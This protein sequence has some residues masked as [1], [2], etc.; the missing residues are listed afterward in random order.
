[1]KVRDV[2]LEDY[3]DRQLSTSLKNWAAWQ[4]P[5]SGDRQRLLS[6]AI[7]TV[8]Q[9]RSLSLQERIKRVFAY[10]EE[11]LWNTRGMVTAPFS[12]ASYWAFHRATT[13]RQV[14]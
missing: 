2:D 13:F 1:M 12:Q 5:P 4:K 8:S 3:T 6:A 14:T 7:I 9:S 10:S 11:S